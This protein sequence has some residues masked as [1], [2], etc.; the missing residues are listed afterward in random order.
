MNTDR[1]HLRPG[2]LF[3]HDDCVV[4]S[5]FDCLPGILDRL[6]EHSSNVSNDHGYWS[7]ATHDKLGYGVLGKDLSL[8][9]NS[10]I[11][12]VC[13]ERRNSRDYY[14]SDGRLKK[15]VFWWSAASRSLLETFCTPEGRK[16]ASLSSL[17][18]WKLFLWWSASVSEDGSK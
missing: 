16:N 7:H 5:V 13:H 8:K 11:F 9:K 15:K 17:R 6:Q 1:G 14:T 3:P 10:T 4:E 12:S 2:I 18:P